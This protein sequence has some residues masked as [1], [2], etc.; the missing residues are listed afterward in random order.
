MS[1]IVQQS[2]AKSKPSKR[3]RLTGQCQAYP[4]TRTHAYTTRIFV[5]AE[6]QL[7]IVQLSD[8]ESGRKA[9]WTHKYLRD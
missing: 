9:Q 7:Q 2:K 6:A 4:R 1:S 5:A 8:L 3:A